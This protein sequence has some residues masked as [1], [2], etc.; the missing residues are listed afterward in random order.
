MQEKLEQL[1]ARL[2]MYIDLKMA[3]N[4][5]QWDQETYM[6]PGG[7]QARADQISTLEGL[8]HQHLSDEEVGSLLEALEKVLDGLE[9]NSDEASLIRYMLREYKKAVKVPAE[10]IS[11]LYRTTTLA[12]EAWK[13]ARADNNFSHFEPHLSQ[14]VDLRT[15]YAEA[16]GSESGNIYD[17]LLD[18]FDPGLTSTYIDSVFSGLKPHLV[19]L[20]SAIVANQ[21]AVDDSVLMQEFDED[22]QMVFGREVAAAIGYDF[23]RGRLDLTAHPFTINFSMDDVRITTRIFREDPLSGL[24]STVHEA[25]HA[26][27]E[28]NISPSLYRTPLAEGSGMSVHESQS[29]FYENV[30]GRSRGFWRH[31]FPR[32]QAAFAPQFDGVELEEFYKALN[33]S[34][35]SLIRVEADEV[36]Y[37]L[38]IILRFELENDLFNGRVK[39]ADLPEEW[40]AR[41]EQYLGIVPPTDSDGVMQDIHWAAGLMGYFPDYLLGSIMSVQLWEKLQADLPG[42]EGQIEAGQYAAILDWQRENIHRHGKKFTFPELVERA[43]GSPLSWEPYMNY[44]KTKYSDIYGL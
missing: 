5:L 11:D 10:L 21:D 32:M 35:P 33:K 12:T 44:L 18:Y 16:L 28:Q 29:R 1:K 17:A 9:Y 31:W 39:V 19:E 34:E 15:Q 41:M 22:Q 27:Y 20:V 6:P 24:M 25:G 37:G 23:E 3:S 14:V 30:L 43:T 7:A 36:T 38:H 42:V 2:A 26:M 13:K 40:N 8:A 4:V